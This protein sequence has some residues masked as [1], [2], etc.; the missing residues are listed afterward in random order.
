MRYS[1]NRQISI[2]APITP[3]I[4]SIIIT[5]GVTFI[6]QHLAGEKVLFIFGLS[7]HTVWEKFFFW[8]LLTYLFL[9]ND[10]FQLFFNL[11]A[12]YLFGAELEMAWGSWFFFKYFFLTGI[13]TGFFTLFLA[14]SI[15]IPAVGASGAIFGILL[16]YALYS[17]NRIVFFNFVLPIKIKYLVVIYGLLTFYFSLPGNGV[18]IIH[19]APLGGGV[20]GFIYLNFYSLNFLI[21]KQ[22]RKYKAARIRKH[23]R[24]IEGGKKLQRG[25]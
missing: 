21:M 19:L 7:P 25:K 15:S 1:T 9:N 23:Y 5:S 20:F 8:Q 14:P 18:N 13:S 10:F 3:V 11:L 22:I 16:A 24:V 4:K 17:P 12:L 2:G 6:L